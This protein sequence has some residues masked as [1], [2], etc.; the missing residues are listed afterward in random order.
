MMQYFMK[1]SRKVLPLNRTETFWTL[2]YYLKT[3]VKSIHQEIIYYH[4][5]YEPVQY[6]WLDYHIFA[7]YTSFPIYY[8]TQTI[9]FIFTQQLVIA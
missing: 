1:R 3:D 8:Q 2:P 9:E 6:R 5:H 4:D 7:I